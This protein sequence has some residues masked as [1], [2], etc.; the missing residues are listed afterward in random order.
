MR[1]LLERAG[2]SEPAVC[3]RLSLNAICDF[4]IV[5]NETPFD[6]DIPDGAALLTRLFLEGGYVTE[7]QICRLLGDGA[8][9]ILLG[10]GLVMPDPPD[11]EQWSATALLYPTRG[12][13]IASDRAHNA[14]GSP[15]TSPPD[16]VYPAIIPNTDLFLSLLPGT[17][18]GAFLDLCCGT[19][20]A[21][22]VAARQSER[23]WAT[24]IAS[25]STHFTE[26][27]RR[28]NGIANMTVAESDVYAA[29]AGQTFDRIAV[30]PPYVPVFKQ[31]WIFDSGGEDGE[32]VTRRVVMGLPE[33]LRPGGRLYCLAMGSDRKQPFE[34]R[35]REWLGG[36]ESEFDV[37]FFLRKT[38]DP[39]EYAARSVLARNGSAEEVRAFQA[40]F[41]HLEIRSLVYGLI[42][43]QRRE[44]LRATFTVRR[45]RGEG[46]GQP[47]AEWLMAW[48]TAAAR[49]DIVDRILQLRVTAPAACQLKTLHQLQGGEWAPSDYALSPEHPFPM[50]SKTQPAIAQMLARCDGSRTAREHLEELKAEGLFHPDTPPGAFAELLKTMI[51]GGFLEIEGHRL[52]PAP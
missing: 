11:A 43:I 50:E 35:L 51:S 21:A 41:R 32:Q 28:L 33:H 31:Q 39:P 19:G 36:R 15:F 25:R 8:L 13:H 37:G 46:V 49:S 18:C 20:I 24:D 27:N 16:I 22:L 17:R 12:L 10:L 47:E 44:A 23:S 2:Y 45:Q 14:D 7:E 6:P 34:L 42:V 48:E 3:A 30:H 38:L 52:P 40:Q 26:F 4:K 29:V 1:D 9:E 5:G